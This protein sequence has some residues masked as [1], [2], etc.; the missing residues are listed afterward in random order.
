MYL[1][2]ILEF[3]LCIY[4]FNYCVSSVEFNKRSQYLKYNTFD[5]RH[6]HDTNSL[7]LLILYAF[8]II[9]PNKNT[10]VK[11]RV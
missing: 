7:Y 11:K 6:Q 5:V 3:K 4:I 8:Y 2:N 9:D 10:S 1:R